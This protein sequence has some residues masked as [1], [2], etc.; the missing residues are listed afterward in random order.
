MGDLLLTPVSRSRLDEAGGPVLSQGSISRGPEAQPEVT[1]RMLLQHENEV[2]SVS[3]VALPGC[4]VMSP[5]PSAQ[6]F[7]IQ[8]QAEAQ[9]PE[10]IRCKDNNT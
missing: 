8:N 6:R 4:G 5:S 1:E 7:T 9:W 3:C 10:C 2:S